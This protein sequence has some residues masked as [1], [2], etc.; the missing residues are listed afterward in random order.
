MSEQQNLAIVRS[1]YDAFGH[2][3]LDGILGAL[4]THP[5]A[6]GLRGTCV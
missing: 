6:M 4:D 5:T 3:D 2:G 1:M